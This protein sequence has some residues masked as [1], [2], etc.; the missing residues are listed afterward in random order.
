M[1]S[2]RKDARRAGLLYLIAV[3]SGVISLIY[4]PSILIKWQDP[5]GTHNNILSNEWLFKIGILSDLVLYIVF[6]F[7]VL[8]LYKLLRKTNENI[9]KIMVILVLVSVPLS[10]ANLIGKFDILSLVTNTGAMTPVD[11]NTQYVQMMTLLESHNNGI[12]VAEVF[13]GLWLFPFGYLVFNSGIIPKIMGVFLML[14]SVAYLGDFLGYFLF[15]EDFG[16]TVFPTI[17][18]ISQALGE[19]GICL[20]LLIFGAKEDG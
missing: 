7:L 3:I 10:C 13:W 16:N 2:N 6:I 17:S 8:A 4:V 18:S 1:S 19:M 9:A 14:A 11:I 20:W 15:P 12:L 5:A